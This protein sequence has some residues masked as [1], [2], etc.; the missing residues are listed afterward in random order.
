MMEA[1]IVVNWQTLLIVIVSIVLIQ[2]SNVQYK[3]ALISGLSLLA[4][5]GIIGVAASQMAPRFFGDFYHSMNGIYVVANLVSIIN[6]IGLILIVS[7]VL[8]LSKNA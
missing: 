8:K 4:I 3:K 2:K 7:S 5:T 6:S 1:I